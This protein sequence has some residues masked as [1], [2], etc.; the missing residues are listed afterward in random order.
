MALTAQ[1]ILDMQ[2]DL[3][4]GADESVFTDAELE[5][6]YTRA[7]DDYNTAVYYA[8]RQILAGSAAWVDYAVAQTKVSRS[9][10]F[11]HIKAMVTFWGGERRTT[12]NQVLV[13]GANP[14]PT[15]HKNS[16]H[17]EYPHAW[18]YRRTRWRY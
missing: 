2:A 12:A 17:D 13:V 10:A 8:W 3:A 7:G 5:A 14:V 15:V 18:P 6:L 4:I 9:Q 11:D 1:Q 16:P